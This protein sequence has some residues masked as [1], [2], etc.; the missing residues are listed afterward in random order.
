MTVYESPRTAARARRLS[1][2]LLR[3]AIAPELV[4]QGLDRATAV[5]SRKA[6][7]DMAAPWAPGWLAGMGVAAR[8]IAGSRMRHAIAAV[9]DLH[10]AG[11]PL[12]LGTDS[13]TWPLLHTQFPGW[14]AIRELELLAEAGLDPAEVLEAGTRSPA[15]MLGLDDEIGTVE[16]GKAGD[17]VVLGADPLADPRAWRSVVYTMRGGE[18]RTPAEWVAR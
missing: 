9:H 3:T 17:L 13:G 1:D 10:E 8:S 16:V 11:V 4:A 7:A 5:R 2:P 18:V 15:R 6:L 12:V 14:A